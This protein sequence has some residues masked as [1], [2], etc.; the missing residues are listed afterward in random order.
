MLKNIKKLAGRDHQPLSLHAACEDH[1]DPVL[2]V[3]LTASSCPAS[4][5]RG[6]ISEFHSFKTFYIYSCLHSC[7][8][9]SACTPQ[10]VQCS[11]RPKGG[12]TSLETGVT[13]SCELPGGECHE[14]NPGPQQGQPVPLAGQH[15][16]Q[17]L[18]CF[19]HS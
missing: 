19:I 16:L 15:L 5:E 9:S 3:R 4:S 10:Y 11:W 13:G 7:A 1:D 8:C 18:F 12:S 2:G 6:N 14:P 17:L